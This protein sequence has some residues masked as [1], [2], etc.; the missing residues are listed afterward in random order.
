MLAVGIKTFGKCLNKFVMQRL[1]NLLLSIED[2]VRP[3]SS[4]YRLLRKQ[5]SIEL[6]DLRKPLVAPVFS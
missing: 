5:P 3:L 4:V 2:F 1:H 6:Q